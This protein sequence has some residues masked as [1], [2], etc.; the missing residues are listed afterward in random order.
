MRAPTMS[1]SYLYS[2]VRVYCLAVSEYPW[3]SDP[4]VLQLM[5]SQAIL[6]IRWAM[7]APFHGPG[8][9]IKLQ[10]V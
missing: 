1:I 8:T 5:V 3:L 6:G 4:T 7:T 2:K 9:E 10:D